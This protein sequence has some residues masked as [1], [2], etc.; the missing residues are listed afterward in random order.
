MKRLSVLTTALAAVIIG[1]AG[2]AAAADNLWVGDTSAN[3]N[4][5]NWTN[6][7]AANDYLF[8]GAAGAAGAALNNDTAAN[9][10]YDALTFNSGASAF[11]IAGNAINLGGSVT[12]NSTS[13][14]TIN[15]DLSPTGDLGIYAAGGGTLM[16]QRLTSTATKTATLDGPGSVI[17]PG[18]LDNAF[19][20]YTV[21]AGT[22]VLA[23]ASAGAIHSVGSGLALNAGTVQLAGTGGDQI[24]DGNTV[25]INGGLFDMNGR[26]E[27]ITGLSGTGGAITNSSATAGILTIGNSGGNFSYAG[28]IRG[29][30]G[31]VG[32]TKVGAGT[33]TLSGNNTYTGD[34]VVRQGAL[35]ITGSSTG[36]GGIYVVPNIA[37]S[38]YSALVNIAGNVTAYQMWLGDRAGSS[39]YGAAYQTAGTVTLTRAASVDDLRI[40]STTGGEGYYK[41][42]GGTLIANE[43]GV[44][45]SLN[46]T[47]G[48]MDITGGTFQDNGWITIGRGGGTS[49]GILNIMGG[50]AT[51]GNNIAL[52]NATTAGAQ[53]VL[54]IS[55]A[56]VTGPANAGLN[57]SLAMWG[58]VAGTLG[59]ANLQSG[60][61]LAI[62]GVTAWSANPTALLNFN[63]GTLKAT[64]ANAAF[65]TSANIDNVYV[66]SGG[67]TIDNNGFGITISRPLEAPIGNGVATIA[68]TNGGSGYVGAPMVTV[69]GGTGAG[70]TAV[71]NM[72]DDG[73]GNGTFRVG[74][75][76][77]TSP[78]VYAADPTTVTLRGG[79]A[80]TAAS[81]FTIGTA[82][83]TGG[84]MTFKGI[85]ITT[86][87]GTNT[88]TGGTTVNGGA[89]QI[90]TD[91]QLG[92]IP[93]T[94][95]VNVTL[96]G[97]TLYNNSSSPSVNAN[98][99]ISLG[100][101]GGYLQAGWAPNSLTVNGQI[102]GTGGLGI[103]WDAGPVILGAANNYQGN[104]TIGTA[105][106]W[107]WVDNAASPTLKLGIDNAL[108][109]GASAGNVLFGTSANNNTATLDLNGHNAQ[110]N[111]LTGSANAT[112]DNAAGTG[113]YVL[114]V[115]NNDQPGTFG[116]VIKNTSGTV[117]LTKTGAGA[118]TLSGAN[119]YGGGT[120]VDAGTL[121]LSGS[122]S[123]ESG[124]IDIRSNARFD[125]SGTTAG[126]F[127]LASGR[128]LT[129]GGAVSGGL[130][131]GSGAHVSGGGSFGGPVTNQSGGFLTPGA[132]GHTNFF[133]SLTLNGGSTNSFYV[134]PTYATHD[135]SAVTNRLSGNGSSPLLRL[136]LGDYTWTPAD[137]GQV[138]VL[139]DDLSGGPSGF[140]GSSSY[141]VLSDPGAGAL[142]DGLALPEGTSFYATGNGS[143]SN[144]FAIHY[145]YDVGSGT[146]GAGNDVVLTVIPEP[147][148]V[149]LL[150]LL[151]SACL[152]R[153]RIRGSRPR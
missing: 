1:L 44:G 37:A 109:Y 51:A 136:D 126:S 118:L 6:A 128:S 93:G 70:A 82:A 34:T 151:G 50:T 98:R 23:K 127:T 87:T 13:L 123:I 104:T 38:T 85:A 146:P 143:V 36:G 77:V 125:V 60:G 90:S 148:S 142:N 2:T 97:G 5:A 20:A 43:A 33:Q 52:N 48:V 150:L 16:F 86:L 121:A 24:Y 114:T 45:G 25:T 56:T 99:T 117:A 84:G 63:G 96:N 131:V 41:L 147:E 14:Q 17:L 22:L 57:L 140:D 108:P 132:G 65:M 27:T 73:T 138:I 89:L 67:G 8:F 134:G 26:S 92:A 80:T 7:L 31:A 11:T 9:T 133:A 129:N 153:R 59:V 79:G 58:N 130:I 61:T 149:S 120:T 69:A 39:Q 15:L 83:N 47:L 68:V 75:I 42:S 111:G 30:G 122:G 35:N 152:M 144:A 54:N 19:M 32:L 29:G 88:Y 28:A 113:A 12:N 102:T 94:P 100:A 103:N 115:G 18:S 101:S 55:N 4:D 74:S 139:Y 53:S 119:T 62:V 64:V 112:I 49:S 105:G 40:G 66:Y 124:V 72:L 81:G 10:Q 110:I 137:Q 3:W 21:N 78:G 107:Y 71:A 145:N 46:N 106:P 95:T 141:F 135:M 76:T 91:A 116:G